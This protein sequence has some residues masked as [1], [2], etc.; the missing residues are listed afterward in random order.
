MQSRKI[1]EFLL[2]FELV[3]L[4]SAAH[5]KGG[6]IRWVPLNRNATGSP[7]QIMITQ[8]YTYTLSS[9]TCTVGSLIGNTIYGYNFSLWCTL[10]C[11]PAS[12]GY[13]APP[14]LGFCT[15][16]NRGLNL[17]FAQRTDI[18]NVTANASFTVSQ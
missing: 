2:L 7:V 13:N 9:V 15:G 16:F 6:S 3:Y 12:V 10:N 5:F 14:V 11:G 1:Y 17:A 8:T 18:V 4:G